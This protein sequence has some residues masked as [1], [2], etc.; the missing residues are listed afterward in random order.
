MEIIIIAAIANNGVIGYAGKIPWHSHLE[1][2]HFKSTTLG[3]PVL[4]GRKTFQSLE[5]PLINRKN[6]VLTKSQYV[7]SH[8]NKVNYYNS[9]EMALDFC[10][11][12]NFTKLFIIGG[13]ELYLQ[14]M[15]LADKLILS[16][17]KLFTKGDTYFPKIDLNIW[18][19]IKKSDNEEFILEIY[20]K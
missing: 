7:Q 12:N 1:L 16:K 14:T 20:S 8:E 10:Y 2:E 17:M 13:G 18:N 6:L 5:T 3:Y 4:M 15:N 11:N 19:L 9:I